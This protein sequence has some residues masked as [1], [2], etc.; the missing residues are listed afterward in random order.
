[1]DNKIKD[2]EA[3]LKKLNKEQYH[4]TQQC[5]TEKPFNNAYWNNNKPGIY[6][7]VVS[8]E[9]L[10]SSTDKFKSGTGWPS[11]TK[12]IHTENIINKSDHSLGMKRV[13]VCSKHGDSHLGHL[14]EDGPGPNGLRYCINSASLEFIPVN[15]L[16]E[17][18]YGEYLKLFKE[19]A[20]D[21]HNSETATFAGGCFW[22]VEEYF[23]R[24]DGVL[25]V[26]SGYTGGHKDNPTYNEVCHT[27]TGHAEAVEIKYDPKKIS[28]E[29]LLKHFWRVHDPTQ[30]NQQGNDVGSQYRSAIFYHNQAQKKAAEKAIKKLKDSKLFSKPI[31]TEI[32]PAQ[33][34]YDAEDYHQDYLKKNPRGYCHVDL[35]KAKAPLK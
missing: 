11:F 30:L 18:G 33:T 10:F 7:D 15:K 25:E 8:G 2:K 35:S 20:V 6:V 13:E 26:K 4:V 16:E 3:I 19:Q 34:F 31:V 21:N 14:F 24:V 27:N 5:G 1:M 12:P 29:D 23:Q 32:K 28:Y 17:R 22:G 9:P